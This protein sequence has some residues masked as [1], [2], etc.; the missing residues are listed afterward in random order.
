MAKK[1]MKRCSTSLIIRVC[2]FLKTFRI[3]QDGI[4]MEQGLEA[5]KYL[6]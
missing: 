2:S 1:H 5:V 6:M 4:M 3:I